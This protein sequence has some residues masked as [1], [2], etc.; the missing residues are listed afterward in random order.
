MP[1]RSPGRSEVQTSSTPVPDGESLRQSALAASW[2]R[3]RRVARR[4]L[5]WRWTL[6]VL[7]R[8]G[9]LLLVLAALI[10][11]AIRY[12]QA[13]KATESARTVSLSSPPR[14]TGPAWPSTMHTPRHRHP[15][16]QQGALN[17]EPEPC[18]HPPRT[19]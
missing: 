10:L 5:L 13:Q 17:H 16:A 1:W 9:W 2:R 11:A 4:R 7:A 12:S 3:D 15:V 18:L 14:A 19:G 6:W 8:Y